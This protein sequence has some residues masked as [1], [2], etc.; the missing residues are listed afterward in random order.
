MQIFWTPCI[1]FINI[2]VVYKTLK[3][4]RD[5]AMIDIVH[6]L[7]HQKYINLLWIQYN[8]L[9]ITYHMLLTLSYDSTDPGLYIFSMV[10][11]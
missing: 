2:I 9:L 4:R 10:V 1:M 11:L 6:K 7:P 8:T 5:H 3:S